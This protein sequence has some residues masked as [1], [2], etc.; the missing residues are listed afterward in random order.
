MAKRLSTVEELDALPVGSLIRGEDGDVYMAMFVPRTNER[1]WGA[2]QTLPTVTTADL[3]RHDTF[4]ILYNPSLG[5]VSV[6]DAIEEGRARAFEEVA[7]ITQY[8]LK[9]FSAKMTALAA[10]ARA[11][12]EVWP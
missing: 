10:E 5:F 9:V 7:D 11:T 4:S 12:I 2:P 1:V 3:L 8:E 6:Y